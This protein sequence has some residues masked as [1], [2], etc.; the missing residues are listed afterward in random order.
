[1]EKW[2]C[3]VCGYT[4][5]GAEAPDRCPQCGALK[6]QFNRES[7]S[8]WNGFRFLIILAILIAIY[9]AF[10]SCSSSQEVN[11]TPVSH[12]DLTRYQGQWYEIARLDHNFE[13]GMDQ[14]T[15][16]YQLQDN[17]K[18]KIT[19]QGKKKGKWKTS[20]GKGK[21][22]DTPG[23][24]RVSFFGPFYS[25]YRILM[26]AP[27][28]SYALIG[29]NDEDYLWILSRTPQME[30]STLERIVQEAHLRGYDTDDL[31]WVNQNKEGYLQ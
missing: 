12:V 16:T 7:R 20:V 24:L 3:S 30:R 17:G 22:T 18:I 26:L 8:I 31:I 28:Y 1:M 27:D 9:F 25:D 13:R 23:I 19:N 11:N 29:G 15:A 6:A 21:T 14:C 5:H 2:I 10:F 4:H